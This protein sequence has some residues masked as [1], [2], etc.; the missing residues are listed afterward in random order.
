MIIHFTFPEMWKITTLEV[1][2]FSSFANVDF[3]FYKDGHVTKSPL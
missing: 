2:T 3:V 1:C